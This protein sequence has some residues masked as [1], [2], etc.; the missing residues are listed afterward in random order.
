MI[1]ENE[2]WLRVRDSS[3]FISFWPIVPSPQ[4]PQITPDFNRYFPLGP[5]YLC[6][7]PNSSRLMNR[8]WYGSLAIQRL[9]PDLGS[10]P[11]LVHGSVDVGI[12][13]FS[14]LIYIR[15]MVWSSATRV[16]EYL[17]GESAGFYVFSGEDKLW[18]AVS[19]KPSYAPLGSWWGRRPGDRKW[20]Q[21][22]RGQRSIRWTFRLLV[23]K[24]S[25]RTQ[26]QQ[27]RK[28]PQRSR[29]DEAREDVA[30]QRD[31]LVMRTNCQDIR[32]YKCTK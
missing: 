7:S 13:L 28:L 26:L 22:K 25:R 12:T 8:P 18:L 9:Y 23:E 21:V 24:W 32:A 6:L 31:G 27:L 10:C 14:S 16:P 30:S 17:H 2:D 1:D 29:S 20:Y 19:W 5:C 11:L 3:I 15:T 4:F